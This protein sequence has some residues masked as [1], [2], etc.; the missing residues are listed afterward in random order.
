MGPA[1]GQRVAAVATRVWSSR[2]QTKPGSLTVARRMTLH[3][4]RMLMFCLGLGAGVLHSTGTELQI[5]KPATQP[6]CKCKRTCF[7]PDL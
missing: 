6:P 4:I 7:H 1:V 3:L 2:P 5:S